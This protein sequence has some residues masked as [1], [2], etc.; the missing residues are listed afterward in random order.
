MQAGM[1]V[2]TC[3][4]CSRYIN[5]TSV[6]ALSLPLRPPPPPPPDGCFQNIKHHTHM[7]THTHTHTFYTHSLF[8]SPTLSVSLCLSVAVCLSVS[9]S[10]C[11][12]SLTPKICR[13]CFSPNKQ[14]SFDPV[15]CL[16]SAYSC[17]WPVSK[18]SATKP[19]RTPAPRFSKQQTW[20]ATARS[21]T[22]RGTMAQQ[23]P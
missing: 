14:R 11:L 5:Y 18:S 17:T 7:Q 8:F 22:T 21:P 23:V 13:L 10:L 19:R 6:T 1:L 16:D 4:R 3:F 9:L 12:C 15:V 2:C 20:A